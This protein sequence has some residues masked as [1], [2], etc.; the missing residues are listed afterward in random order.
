MEPLI[1]SKLWLQIT[2]VDLINF[3]DDNDAITRRITHVDVQS[4]MFIQNNLTINISVNQLDKKITKIKEK[5]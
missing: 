2:L 4:P 3:W 5:I 1:W